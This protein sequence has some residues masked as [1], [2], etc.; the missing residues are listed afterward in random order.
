MRISYHYRT[1]GFRLFRIKGLSMTL[2]PEDTKWKM[3]V[4]VISSLQSFLI[5][6]ALLQVT[7]FILKKLGSI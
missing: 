4:D 1:S 6:A 5:Y 2:D 7:A 3:R